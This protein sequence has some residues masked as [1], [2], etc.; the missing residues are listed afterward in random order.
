MKRSLTGFLTPI[1][2]VMVLMAAAMVLA[3]VRQSVAGFVLAA[4]VG[5]LL[6]S[7]T[8]RRD[9]NSRHVYRGR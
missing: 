9:A 3:G 4:V 2:A 8:A 6:I 1:I 5:T 7:W